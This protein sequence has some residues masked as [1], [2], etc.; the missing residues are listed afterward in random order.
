MKKWNLYRS[1]GMQASRGGSTAA[2]VGSA[3]QSR[4]YRLAM[5][6]FL[7]G[8]TRL[9]GSFFLY[10]KPLLSSP[11]FAPLTDKAI[12][13]A[14][15]IDYGVPVWKDGDIDIAPEYLYENG[16]ACEATA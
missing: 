2:D 13:G 11:A 16:V 8:C 4:G 12:F 5:Q 6:G 3:K 1:V 7:L 10:F 15:Y 9:G 14:V